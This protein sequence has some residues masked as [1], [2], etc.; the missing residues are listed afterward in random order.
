MVCERCQ[1]KLKS[2]ICPDVAKKA[3]YKTG[4]STTKGSQEE[5][6]SDKKVPLYKQRQAASS[7]IGSGGQQVDFGAVSTS[8]LLSKSIVGAKDD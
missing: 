6:K 8:K 5:Q 2:V 1:T 3:L 7:A 4:A